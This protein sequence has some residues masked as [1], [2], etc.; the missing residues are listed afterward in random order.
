MSEVTP[1]TGYRKLSEEEIA[2]MNAVKQHAEETDLLL[3]NLQVFNGQRF[4]SSPLR[5]VMTAEAA[6]QLSESRRWAA[7]AK[8][9]LQQGFMALN[10]AVALPT[11]F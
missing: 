1:I 6:E 2:F 4:G 7:L 3:K 5:P 9:Q 11:T 8:T 10:R